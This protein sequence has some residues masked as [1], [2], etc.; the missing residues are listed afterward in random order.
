MAA[1]AMP[2]RKI[3]ILTLAMA[4]STSLRRTHRQRAVPA[5]LIPRRA[6]K[7]SAWHLRWL[8]PHPAIE[9]MPTNEGRAASP[10]KAVMRM[11]VLTVPKD[12]A[13]G[14]RPGEYRGI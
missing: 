6:A 5:G 12:C 7:K 14:S 2:I 10:V 9:P 8:Q 4:P 1:S 3:L 13:I 11:R